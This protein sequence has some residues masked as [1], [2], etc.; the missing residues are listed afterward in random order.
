M[1]AMETYSETTLSLVPCCG[2]YQSTY[3]P[4]YLASCRETLLSLGFS[5]RVVPLNPS[6]YTSKGCYVARVPFSLPP[7]STH[8]LDISVLKR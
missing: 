5:V 7:S 1:N 3:L 4:T 8:S 6:S 2:F